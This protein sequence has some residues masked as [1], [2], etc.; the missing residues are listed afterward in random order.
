[1]NCRRLVQREIRPKL[2]KPCSTDTAHWPIHLK[3]K[4]KSSVSQVSVRGKGMIVP[5][6]ARILRCAHKVFF[7]LFMVVSFVCLWPLAPA[8]KLLCG[9]DLLESFATPGLWSDED[10]SGKGRGFSAF[11]A[12][13]V[14]VLSLLTFSRVRSEVE[15][16]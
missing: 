3:K 14:F 11:S 15:A 8:V 12:L 16:W 7:F 6:L 4:K 9:A 1:M 13:S 2:G 5:V 10:V